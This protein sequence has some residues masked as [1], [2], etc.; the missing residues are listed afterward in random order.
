MG[1]R[2]EKEAAVSKIGKKAEITRFKGLGEISGDEFKDFIGPDMRLQDVTLSKDETIQQI[3]NFY[4]GDN[5]QQRQD[6][7]RDNLRTT[8][9]MEGIDI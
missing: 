3:L 9:Q 2:G 6:F 5:T 4:M 1:D 8:E 7:I